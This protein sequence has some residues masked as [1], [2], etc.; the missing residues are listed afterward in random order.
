MSI[1]RKVKKGIAAGSWTRKMFDE[2]N[3]LKQKY[4]AANVFD[5][6]IGNP[7]I[8]P[9]DSFV[10]ELQKLANSPFP[11][12]HRYM[13]NAGYDDT[14]A[15]IAS[16]LVKDFGFKFSASEVI[17]TVGA[18][19][20]LNL[21]LK[22]ILNQNDEVI[23]I[24]PY[25]SEYPSYVS[26]HSGIVK[27]I[28]SDAD[29]L[30]RLDLIEAAINHKTKAVIINSPNN[31]SGVVYS[32]EFLAE[33]GTLLENMET[34]HN[35]EIYL[36]SD[37]AY[38]K[39]IF[40]GLKYPTPLN[41]YQRTMIITS[42]SKDLSLPGERIGYLAIHPD[43][44]EKKDLMDALI[45]CTRAL[46][47]VNAP[48][49]MQRIVKN[50]QQTS[51]SVNE[52]QRKRDFLY[53]KLSGLGYTLKKPQGTFYLFP[54]TPVADDVAFIRDLQHYKVLTVPGSGYGMPG[55]FRIAFC[56]DDRTL[57]GSINGFREVAHKYG[58]S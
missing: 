4:G 45:F 12:M 10:L 2:G 20:A 25:F 24:S 6:S 26:S 16:Q 43:C 22:A 27:I 30:P 53:T 28:P 56:V 48:A 9:P 18:A 44:S 50:L 17:M 14:R 58:L 57:E 55:Y 47:Y 15:A 8:E 7:L 1:S 5:L 3:I 32:S 31:P 19:A 13:P 51:V 37:E 39:I 46:G 29:F 40:D 23:L 38:R 21:A 49:L 35:T 52:Y 34:K 11:G 42:H 33:L 54:K 41:H 36:I